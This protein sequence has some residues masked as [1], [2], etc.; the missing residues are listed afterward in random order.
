MGNYVGL[1]APNVSKEL[2]EGKKC[3]VTMDELCKKV[4]EHCLK[5]NSFP[6]LHLSQASTLINAHD[7][8]WR[9]HD[10]AR[11]LD[12]SITSH[13]EI[14]QRAQLQVARFQWLHEDIVLN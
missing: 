1:L 14:V 12:V 10:L 9:K 13:K 2:K 4:V 3:V 6:H 8:A 11:R 5:T 7:V